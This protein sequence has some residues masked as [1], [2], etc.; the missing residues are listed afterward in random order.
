[1]VFV[2]V[3]VVVVEAVAFAFSNKSRVSRVTWLNISR[4]FRRRCSSLVGPR[5]PLGRSI[6]S[7]DAKMASGSKFK[8]FNSSSREGAGEVGWAGSVVA[9]GEAGEPKE[10]EVKAVAGR[11]DDA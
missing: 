9:D 10:G 5:P 7:T 11:D 2:A 6:A 1:M 8:L 4:V 3:V